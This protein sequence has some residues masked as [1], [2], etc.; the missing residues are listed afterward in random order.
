HADAV[1]LAQTAEEVLLGPG[2]LEGFLFR[3]Q[4]LRH[5]ATNHPAD[6]DANLLLL[7]P[8]RAHSLPLL[9]SP[10]HTARGSPGGCAT[11]PRKLGFRS[12][13]GPAQRSN[14][15]MLSGGCRLCAASVTCLSSLRDLINA[16]SPAQGQD[17]APQSGQELAQDAGQR[18]E[19][20][21]NP[22]PS[23][24]LPGRSLQ[25][26]MSHRIGGRAE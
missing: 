14:G 16:P 2:V 1:A 11:S 20:R 6:V 7:R 22:F 25:F 18:R 4:D 12:A 19:K 26:S 23:E 24:R 15:E 3:L 21:G 10:D 13:R 9:P 8:V 5:V 17:S